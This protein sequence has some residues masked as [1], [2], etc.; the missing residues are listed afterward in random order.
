MSRRTILAVALA[1]TNAGCVLP[2]TR[3]QQNEPHRA[4]TLALSSDAVRELA[5]RVDVGSITLRHSTTDSI[6]IIA[7]LVS[8][9]AERLRE[10]CAPAMRLE[11]ETTGHLVSLRLR[12]AANT[13]CGERWVVTLPANVKARLDVGVVDVT[14]DS[15]RS[16]LGIDGRGPGSV[17]GVTDSP[18]V[19]VSM[20]LGS[21]ELRSRAG[22]LRHGLVE[23]KI[24][25]VEL[26]VG[27]MRV[28]PDGR[29]GP[30]SRTEVNGEGRSSI[31]LRTGNGRV[32][33]DAR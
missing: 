26:S 23:S 13:R 2:V 28:S 25:S 30:G 17:R 32:T 10:V 5:I 19:E 8:H 14:L 6:T 3:L 16:E 1:A 18:L 22:A 15:V 21:I 4:A 20:D 33:L 9:D 31:R 11:R 7:D 27:G 29:P 24:G 12:Q